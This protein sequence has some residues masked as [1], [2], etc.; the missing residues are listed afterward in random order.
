MLCSHNP[1]ILVLCVCPCNSSSDQ[2]QHSSSGQSHVCSWCHTKARLCHT[3]GRL[4]H[5]AIHKCLVGN[6]SRCDLS[7]LAFGTALL[8]SSPF[9][10][11]S[12]SSGSKLPT[13]SLLGPAG[14]ALCA[15]LSVLQIKQLQQR[16]STGKPH[17]SKDCLFSSVMEKKNQKNNKNQTQKAQHQRALIVFK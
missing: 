1:S 15:D 3:K 2:T 12:T 17:Q 16:R 6:D 10:F 4:C 5:K 9:G 14:S 11:C 8:S 7:S 13:W